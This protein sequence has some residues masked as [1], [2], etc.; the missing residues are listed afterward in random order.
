MATATGRFPQEP[1]PKLAS[2]GMEAPEFPVTF[3][4]RSE[5]P[6]RSDLLPNSF[7]WFGKGKIR[8]L[9]RGLLVT[10]KRRVAIGFHTTEQR[11]VPAWEICEVY[12]E[13]NSIRVS[14]RGDARN[15]D[16]FQFW[17]GDAATAGTVVR[18]LPT[19][20]T[21]EIEHEE[22]AAKAEPE[23]ST[24]IST[25]R[26]RWTWKRIGVAAAFMAIIITAGLITTLKPRDQA[27]KPQPSPGIAATRGAPTTTP[28]NA[29]N[30]A[31]SRPTPQEITN[32]RLT[33]QRYDERMSAMRTEFNMAFTALQYGELSQDDFIKMTNRWL[34]PQW[35]T[36]YKEL[37]PSLHDDLEST[38]RRRLIAATWGWQGGLHEYIRGLQDQN[39][40]TVLGALEQI[41]AA[42]DAQHDA[43]R[44]IQREEP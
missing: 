23:S 43:L 24:P 41:S 44:L 31:A 40:H 2:E 21:I 42:T 22:S 6:S 35:H 12:R 11:V 28:A 39:H 9:E 27:I 37:S 16:F 19:Q 5:S 18:L 34:I 4:R 38:V 36:L 20:R 10:A 13:G 17:T 33:W 32:A 8:L 14:L 26:P 7:R 1:L 25:R 29:T 30:T 15:R 3:S